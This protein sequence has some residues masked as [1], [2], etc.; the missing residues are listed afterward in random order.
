MSARFA[1]MMKNLNIDPA[2]FSKEKVQIF[3]TG[4]ISENSEYADKYKLSESGVETLHAKGVQK[5]TITKLRGQIDHQVYNKQ[6]FINKFIDNTLSA[7]E[8]LLYKPSILE[9]ANMGKLVTYYIFTDK[10]TLISLHGLLARMIQRPIKRNNLK[11]VWS[12]QIEIETQ[13]GVIIK[14][15]DKNA[16]TIADLITKHAGLPVNDE[17]L[18]MS[19]DDIAGLRPQEIKNLYSRL[20]YKKDKISDII[21][22]QNVSYFFENDEIIREIRGNKSYFWRTASGTTEFCWIKRALLP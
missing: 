8:R 11:N 14:L 13:D 5:S 1:S 2:M 12:R 3:E 15:G 6:E 9:V 10:S 20:K 4:Y 22:E 21:S 19:L 18:K 7:N 16:N 17:I